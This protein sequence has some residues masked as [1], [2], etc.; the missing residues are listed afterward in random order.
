M[1]V[2]K[3]FPQLLV[4]IEVDEFNKRIYKEDK[5]VNDLINRYEN[6]LS[7]NGRILVRESGT[8]NLIRIM[9]EGED[10]DMIKN[11]VD[12]IVGAINFKL[13]SV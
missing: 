10:M 3:E 6:E 2:I 9:A 7:G 11:I 8:E 12:D 4:N 13:K 1:S 5:E